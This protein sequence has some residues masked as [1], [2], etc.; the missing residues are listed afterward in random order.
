MLIEPLFISKQHADQIKRIINDVKIA[1]LRTV[2][3]LNELNQLV[4]NAIRSQAIVSSASKSG[5]CNFTLCTK[6]CEILKYS[7]KCETTTAPTTTPETTTTVT[8]TPT[9]T[10]TTSCSCNVNGQILSPGQAIVS[11]ASK[12]GLCN[13]TL[14]TKS[15]EILKYSVKCQPTT[16]PT[17][18]PETTTTV[19]V[20][21]TTTATT[22][23]S[24][25]VNGQIL[26]PG[27]A[28]IS[29]ASKSGLC[30]FTL[31]TKSCEILKYT[32]K[33]Q[34]TTAPTTTPETTTTVTVTPTTTAT[35]SCSCNVN[36][37]ILSPGQA[38]VSS[39]SKSGL[40]NF[41]LCTKSCEIL[42]YTG[43]CQTTTAPTTTPETTTTVTVT[44][45]TT[46]TT[47]CS[48]NVNG[49]ILSPGQAIVSSAGKSGLCNFTLCT[50]SCEILKYT[51]K[52][53]T[54][55]APTTTPETT[56]TVTVT[57][58]TTAT[59]SCSCNVNG[60]IL[61]PGQ[62]IVS[63]ASK[64]GLCNFTLCTKSCEILKYTGKCQTTTAPT[65]TPETTT[66]V[67][68]TP[69]TTATTSCSCNVNGQIL[70]PGQAIVSSAGKSGLCNFTLCT[71]SCEILKYTGKCQTT[72]APTTTPETTTTVTVT[73]TTTATTSCSCNVN[74]QILSPGQARVSSAS[75]SGLCN[76]TLCTKSCEILKY[77][78]KCQTTTAPTTTPETTTTVTVT[79][80]TTA[81]TSCSCNVNGQI[82]SP[83][84]AI[85]SSAIKSGLCNFTLCSKS[86]EILKYTG[87]CQTTTA[88]TT[89]PE[90][91]TT[92][93]VT[94]TTTATTSCSCNVNGQI[95]S[96]GQAIV[97][98]ASK[99]GLCNFTLCTKSCEILKYTGK[100]QTTTAPT[101]TP[102][103]TTTVTV[104]PT[105]TATTSCSCNVNGQILSP[106]QAIVSSASKSGL[107]N[108]TLCSKSCE[109]L[110]YTGKCQTTTAPTTTP[111]TTTTVT[112][113]P[114]T[115]ATTSCSCNVNGQIL[116]P[117]QAIVSSASKSGLCHFTLCTKSCEILKYTGKCQTTTAPT[118]TP[119]TTTTV[120]VTPTTT[121]TTSCSCNVNGQI[122]SPGQA[123]VSSASKSGLCNFTLCT[124]SCEILKYTG[125]CQT[126]TAPT[127]TSE[128]TTTVTV[129]PT[130]TA[131]TSCS[132][133]VNGQILSPGQAIVSSASK[134]GLCNFT[135]CTKSCEILKYTGKCQST[136]A[137]T[138]TPET[139]TT[140]TVT[141]TTTATTSC[142]CNV[143]G[144]ILSPGQAIVSSASKSGLCN[145][146]LCTKSCEIL[147]YTGKCQTT[148]A[149]TTTPETTT[150]VTVTPTTTATTSCSCNVNGQILSPGQAIVSSASKS[151]L[152]NFTLCTKS[153]EILKYTGKCQ[154]T[155]A[156][157]TTH[158][159]TTTVTVTPTTTATTSCSCNV[160]GQ[161]LSPGQAIVS[162]ASKSGLC[163][164]T[165]CT[166]S[167]EILK[168]TG[169]CQ[170]TTAPT[171]TPETTTT[172]T[173]TPT[174]TA[175][176][177]CSCNVNGQILSPGQ[178]IVSSASKSGLC[179]FTLCTKS[180]EI[181][182]YTGKCQTTTAPTTTPETTTTVTVTPTTTATTSCSCNVN[183]QILSPGQAIVSSASKSGLCN[184][185]LCTKSC[186]ILKYTGKCQTTT[187]PTTTPETTTTVTV[188][189]TT[190]A[191]TSC[192]CN[193]NGQILSP[194]QAIVSSASKSG[195]CNFTLC[196]KSCE[197]LK[198]TGKCQTTTAP[199]TTP[200]TTTTVTVT[201]TT[202]ATTSCSCNVNGQILSPGQAI[203][204]SASK[205]GL[206][207]FTL[208]TKSCEILKYTGKC[209]TTTAPTTTSETTTTVTV[210]P[211]TTATT[212]C[213]CNVN[214]QI[215]SPGQAIVSSAS[216]SGLCNFT[217]CTKSCEILKY[218]GKCQTT[219]APTTTPETTTT[220]TVT[221]TTTA[222]TSCSCNVNG[223]ILSPGQ[224]IVSSASKSGLCNFTL[225]TKSCE[226]LK[227][228]GK[229][230]T[231][232][233]P[234]T[235]PETTTTV[236]VTPTTTAT[237]SCSCNV[238]G[239]I[240]SPGQAIVSS[241]SKSG[242]CNFTLCTK[243]CEILK[244]TGKCQ[245]TT[246]PTTTPE[247][248]TTVTVTPTTTATTS[249]KCNVNG[250]ILSP[251]QA[252]V[253]SASK[254]G[255]CNF[256]LCTK[257]CEI[258]KYTGK[259][260]T[261][262]APTTTPE[263]TTT[264]TVTPTTTATTSCSCNV[265]G[266]I[267]SPGQAIVSSA[268]KSGLCNFTLCTKSCEILKYTGK[269]QTTTAPTTTPETTTTVTVTPTTTATTSCSCN[270]NG[271]ILSPGQAI[272][273]SASKSG[274]CNFTLCTKSCEILKYTGKCQTTTAPTTTPE[275]TTTVTVTPT[276]TATTSCSCNVNGQ[277]L[278]PG[279]AIVSSASKSGLCNF[280]L[281]T[282]SCE[283]LKYTGKCQ[284]TT[285][286]TTTPETTTT[287]TV[288][289]TTT[290]TTSC[291]CNV[292]GQK[293]SPG[294]A[295][296]SSAS[297]SGLCNFTLC[298]KS[299][300]ILKYTG[301]CQTTTAPT[302]TPETTTTVTV[303]PT[304]TATTSCSCNVNGQIL[305]P[306]QAI[307][308]SASKSGLCNFTLCT[309]S[310]EILKYTGKCQTTTAPTT[311]PET[312][313][314]VT[315]TP[316]TTATTSCKCNVNGQILSPGQAIVSS[317]SKSGLCNFT[318]CTKSCEILK[319][320]GKCQTTT[321]PTTTPETTTT[322]TVTPTTTAT[323]SC[324]CNVNGQILSPGQAIVS[325]A[326]KSGLC[327]FT[328]CTKSCEILKYT[329]KCQTTTAPTTT[330][331]TT[332]TVTVTPTTTA[333][334]SCSCNVNGQILSPGQAIVS[335]ASKSGLCNFTLCTKSCEILKY[336]GK[337]QTTTAP[338]TT[339]E[340]TTT[341]TVT[342]TTTATTSC[343]C[344]VNGQILSPGQAIVSSASKSGLCNFTLC[345]K[346]CEILKYTGKC[347]TTTAPT[348]TPE[349]TTTVTVTPT[350]TAT[351]SCSCNVNG[352]IL[353]P[354]QAIVSSAS[355]SGLCNFTLCTKSCEILK[356]TGKCQTT[357]APT[358][359]PETTTT[360]T[361][362][363]TTTATTSC[364]C[365]VNGQKLSPGQAIVS[366]AS[367]SGLCNFTLCTKSC[368]I[369][370]Y[371]GKC[372]T[373]TAPTTTPETTTTVTVTPTTTAT[374]SCSCNVNGQILS[375]GQAIVSSASKSGLCNFTLCT[376]SCEI[377]KYT[378]KCQ[379]TTAPTTTPETTTTVTVTPT[380]TATTSC[381]CNV[382]GQILS[383]GQAIV[384][385]ASKSGLC[386]FTLCTK[387][388]EILKY[389]G[390]CQTTT[391]PTT[392]PE[393][394]TTVTVTPTTTATTSCSCN[395]NGQILSPGKF[396][397]YLQSCANH[398][399][400]R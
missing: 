133:N 108:F 277:I 168:Y 68:V 384:S 81:T 197:I 23:C 42:K 181:L 190:T 24:C 307:V 281:C 10:A 46:A 314:T 249:C 41:T 16:A 364:S 263:T 173:V 306:G 126:T 70:S 47:S 338:T 297:K 53:Q 158:E 94:P 342:P 32:G 301:K 66:T 396:I 91:T 274:L 365:N 234:T 72:T 189:P 82:L 334:T 88:P 378:G 371:T 380:T 372:Q 377:L 219:T 9:T 366:S 98:S 239:Q 113:T 270:V 261:T 383:P 275:T 22:S 303:T 55:T 282:K 231:T 92:V 194:G 128:T 328:L 74:G 221:P 19:T 78:G 351:T 130:T 85:V 63:S 398:E 354:G 167:C 244:Y 115:T 97:S 320:T 200:E 362:T 75:K 400:T 127:T 385:S 155:T 175:T 336:T 110:K 51:G 339:S 164:F 216:K 182:K 269:C 187:A 29:S 209:Q 49:Q 119:E 69:I 61:S 131:T 102:E 327:N 45:T 370:K 114:T 235:T 2:K 106:G 107:C 38:I 67:T 100:C 60:Q 256:T 105:T 165:L 375:P 28:I 83:G 15:C 65:T 143:N 368:E 381:S 148:T 267:L 326:S 89:T 290:A 223:Q 321:A 329:G 129:T 204:S 236:T 162:S 225:C 318:L 8:V 332:T 166:K 71:K 218:T 302:T 360:V 6:S 177:S 310:C 369:L 3:Q 64:S 312:T 76:F 174:T 245:T 141:P 341:V 140:V 146:T 311:T 294:Q 73:P 52:C 40:C 226:I 293:L 152:C 387:S 208:C 135:L 183:G 54:T 224:A 17:T 159:T 30:N 392:T 90:T 7:G 305:S 104:T 260:Q 18:T 21:P 238:N 243:S 111:E 359:T 207:N 292:N 206:C 11:S 137:P 12:S 191:T 79:P 80:T 99:S 87:K 283:I 50:K 232:T 296:V 288:T 93:T 13:F 323:T 185:T 379:T 27:Q 33:C 186:E 134:S 212:S 120:T 316:T 246:A 228:T 217:L 193:V 144:Q 179:N 313:T 77:T 180:C 331:E 241:A 211:T 254:S 395:V 136:T 176:T 227:Y 4:A 154:T 132:C 147:K 352:Q 192:S 156:P 284:T 26:S 161:I 95:L 101:T 203:V 367:K 255:L 308:S 240:L 1:V 376:K 386:N 36:G 37:Q 242:L 299:C 153:C 251:G 355:K 171:T 337:C 324:S 201:P 361:V 184:F 286:P 163:N 257:S 399:S 198:Y 347:Q 14:C 57:P 390:K 237:T 58:T 350:T 279:Q 169:K 393:T 276:T 340:T 357:T 287:V 215:L 278:S 35:T 295:I 272:V 34:T 319:Y 196:T 289:P 373:T 145:F 388:C 123:I 265:N 220:V 391:A 333:T 5:L 39:A 300:E 317:A 345:T 309:K 31:C 84:Q 222:T 44:P 149:P 335:S 346:S 250:Q 142:S 121:A 150:T 344:N 160:N 96:P 139:T 271:Q 264:V 325:S 199:T 394:T 268:S 56:T 116:S 103:T 363:P 86:C 233:A 356:Y 253:S 280:T 48:C 259:C 374:T 397:S 172:V 247:T 273:S 112:V 157:T 315:V 349:T 188:T 258:L 109:I 214:G 382:N 151:G 170:T 195:L 124:K 304:T 358:T 210:T 252:I 122:L 262:T 230:Q 59:T 118:T 343:S 213:S 117:G 205:S 125:K 248:T 229:C 348:T 266:Q 43:K 353:S 25:N 322:V 298:T 202:T 20:T 138:T 291:S 62:A 389:T 330:P 178:A 285:A